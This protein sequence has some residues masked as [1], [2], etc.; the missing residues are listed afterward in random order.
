MI[1][2]IV[3]GAVTGLALFLFIFALIPR[4]VGLARKCARR[5]TAAAV[6]DGREIFAARL[7]LRGGGRS[8]QCDRCD[9]A[10]RRRRVDNDIA[11]RIRLPA[12]QPA[13]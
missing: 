2:A 7:A 10:E 4:R 6:H 9:N 3:I 13:R 12:S 1:E 8:R 5:V 11:H